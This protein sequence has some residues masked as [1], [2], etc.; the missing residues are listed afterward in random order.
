MKFSYSVSESKMEKLI[1]NLN[2]VKEKDPITI[3]ILRAE[4]YSKVFKYED[5]LSLFL[6]F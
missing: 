5:S 6:K 4:V 2:L 3:G 1:P